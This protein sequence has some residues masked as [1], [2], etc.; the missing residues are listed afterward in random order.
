MAG[1]MSSPCL[2]RYGKRRKP[3][4]GGVGKFIMVVAD[5]GGVPLGVQRL[6]ASRLSVALWVISG[7]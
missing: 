5:V 4:S 1:R 6:F 3:V 7:L 2:I